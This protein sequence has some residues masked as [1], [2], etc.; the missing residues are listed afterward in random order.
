MFLR[1]NRRKKDGKTHDYWSVGENRRCS[2]GR[3]VQRQVL[4]LGEINA[5][6]REAWRK[7]IELQD[8]GTRRQ[9]ALFPAGSMPVDD[10]DAIGVRLSELSLRRPRQWGACWLALQLLQPLELDSFWRPRLARVQGN[11]PWLKVLK[12]L[13]AYRLIDPGSSEAFRVMEDFADQCGDA[14]L[15]HALGQALRERKPL[16]RFKDVLAAHTAQR[17]AWFA[18]ERPAMEVIARKWC[19]DHDIAP[20]WIPRPSRPTP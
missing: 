7:T 16:R 20:R 18:F 6:Q 9:V 5:S 19:E 13:V 3:V 2:D 1:C 11:T 8:A 17:Q 10:V 12:T 15:A 14:W 4:Y